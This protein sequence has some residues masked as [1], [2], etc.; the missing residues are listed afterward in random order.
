MGKCRALK[1]K[2]AVLFKQ[3]FAHDMELYA[4]F[5]SNFYKSPKFPIETASGVRFS[6]RQWRLKLALGDFN[7]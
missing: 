1:C 6:G 3:T 7:C 4:A 5:N 2:L